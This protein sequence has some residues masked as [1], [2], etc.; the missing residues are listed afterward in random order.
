M[1]TINKIENLSIESLVERNIPVSIFR[2]CDST[3]FS[4][5]CSHVILQGK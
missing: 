4:N 5:Y 2:D 1:L 3:Y